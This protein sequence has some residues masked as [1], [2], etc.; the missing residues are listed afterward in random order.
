MLT[1]DVDAETQR[2]GHQ[3]TH[4]A[5]AQQERKWDKRA[6]NRSTRA[7]PR[8]SP[9]PPLCPV[10]QGVADVPTRHCRERLR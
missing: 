6:V 7:A 3:G 2:R 10:C 9:A 8:N 5:D 4:Q 1:W